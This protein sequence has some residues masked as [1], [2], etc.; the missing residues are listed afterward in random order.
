[1]VKVR[2]LQQCFVD[3]CLRVAGDEFDYDGEINESVLVALEDLKPVNI[4]RPS[5]IAKA[6][7]KKPT[8]KKAKKKTRKKKATKKAASKPDS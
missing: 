2:A 4:P 7:K 3:N 6:S 5:K 1:M 8:T